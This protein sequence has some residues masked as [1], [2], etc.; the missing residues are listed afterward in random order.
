MRC[1]VHKRMP[2]V[3]QC[4]ACHKGICEECIDAGSSLLGRKSQVCEQC[5]AEYLAGE[6][7]NMVAQNKKDLI[8]LGIMAGGYVLGVIFYLSGMGNGGG[9]AFIGMIVCGIWQIPAWWRFS[10]RA[11]AAKVAM[12]GH[13]YYTDEYGVTRREIPGAGWLV[14]GLISMFFGLI[15]TP[16]LLIARGIRYLKDKN[17]IAKFEQNAL[18]RVEKVLG[19][20]LK[21][22][23]AQPTVASAAPSASKP[24]LAEEMVDEEEDV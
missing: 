5:A 10:Q 22:E 21:A 20:K 16:I 8:T 14:V 3:A 12:V 11:G 24:A 4:E 7:K 19:V 6:Y 17:L 1:Y 2:A 18:A 13:S 15:T 23:P 9:N